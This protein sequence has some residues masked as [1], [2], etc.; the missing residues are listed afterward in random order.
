MRV[1]VLAVAVM[2]SSSCVLLGVGAATAV[3]AV[4]G[5]KDFVAEGQALEAEY[6]AERA[7]QADEVRQRY[8]ASEAASR[9]VTV[10][11]QTAPSTP[12]LIAMEPVRK[13]LR[14]RSP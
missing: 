14:P 11:A 4:E 3:L 12:P 5:E 13:P 7:K 10:E 2:S 6:R 8:R 1:L 9:T